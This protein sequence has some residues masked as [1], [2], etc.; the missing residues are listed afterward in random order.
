MMMEGNRFASGPL[1]A[2]EDAG[3]VVRRVWYAQPAVGAAMAAC[4]LAAGGWRDAAGVALGVALGMVNFRFLS[5]SLRSI[6]GAGHETAPQ[7]T[8]L[9]FVF[10][11]IIVGTVAFAIYQTGVA[12]LGGVLTGMFAPAI[13]I[14]LEAIYQAAHAMRHDDDNATR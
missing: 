5:N 14:A 7:G 6:L 2:A 3:A 12:S 8:T 1:W 9:M 10:R 11:W 4:A 13:A